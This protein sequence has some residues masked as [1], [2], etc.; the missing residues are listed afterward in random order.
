MQAGGS[1]AV[2]DQPDQGSLRRARAA[3]LQLASDLKKT[4]GVQGLGIGM[5]ASH[6]EY[7]VHVYVRDERAARSVPKHMDGVDVCIDIVGSIVTT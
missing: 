6:N 3:K 2:S 1:G 4:P 5:N 7:A